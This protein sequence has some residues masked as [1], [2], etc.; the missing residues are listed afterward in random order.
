MAHINAGCLTRA[1][2]DRLIARHVEENNLRALK[3]LH[4]TVTNRAHDAEHLGWPALMDSW[5][6]DAVRVQGAI[7]HLLMQSKRAA[8]RIAA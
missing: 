8:E 7:D 4:T 1:V 2:L 5:M 6:R 3:H